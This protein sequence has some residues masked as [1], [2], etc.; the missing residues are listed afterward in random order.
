MVQSSKAIPM[1]H[2]H[3]RVNES[4]FQTQSQQQQHLPK[5]WQLLLMKWLPTKQ[6]FQ[7]WVLF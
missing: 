5:G 4:S 3:P 2:R 7:L 6:R 1:Q